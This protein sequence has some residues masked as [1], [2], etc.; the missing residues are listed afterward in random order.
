MRFQT[1]PH[2]Q[3]NQ[4][5][6]RRNS[7]TF[8][9]AFFVMPFTEASSSAVA[10][11]IFLH[12][13]EVIEQQ[14]LPLPSYSRNAVHLRGERPVLSKLPVVGNR[15]PVRFVPNPHQKIYAL[16]VVRK[17]ARARPSPERR[18][19][20]FRSAPRSWLWTPGRLLPPPRSRE[21]PAR[22]N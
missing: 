9:A 6:Y 21:A 14:K 22:R 4:T 1:E 19:G 16:L 10:V 3:K 5:S 13:S 18:S 17:Y 8:S 12:A 15:E 2:F 20:L 7:F 11:F